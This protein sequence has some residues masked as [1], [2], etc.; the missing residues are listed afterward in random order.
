MSDLELDAA[1]NRMRSHVLRRAASNRR[2]AIP[3][4]LES[5]VV[6]HADRDVWSVILKHNLGLIGTLRRLPL[7][8]DALWSRFG[9]RRGS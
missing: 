9:L 5:L 7:F 8:A 4:G 6:M 2:L 3:T 1:I